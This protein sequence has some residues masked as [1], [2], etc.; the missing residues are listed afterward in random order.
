MS[1]GAL[2]LV[3]HAKAGDRSTWDGDDRKRPL[4][5]KGH[6]QASRLATSLHPL[7]T[8]HR[9]ARLVSSPYVR[10][11]QTLEPLALLLG[12]PVT[13]DSALAEGYDRDGAL[14]LLVALPVG[15]VLCSHGDVI[16]DVMSALERRG[17]VFTNEPDWRKATC[18]VLERR[19]GDVVQATCWPPPA[20]D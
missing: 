9:E 6:A 15:S 5:K 17:A 19:D 8:P 4:S 11:T 1:D 10:C 14:A 16:P 12:R 3:R 20:D 2:Y 7:V 13:R 18:W